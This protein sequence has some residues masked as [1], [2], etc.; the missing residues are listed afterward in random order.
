MYGTRAILFT[1]IG[2]RSGRLK[3]AG[4]S[5]GLAD[6]VTNCL[7]WVARRFIYGYKIII[8]SKNNTEVNY[9]GQETTTEDSH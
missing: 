8:Y 7:L 9:C 2:L 6:S 1:S 4:G 5:S 3:L